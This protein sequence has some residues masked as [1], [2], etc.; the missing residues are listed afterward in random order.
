VHRKKLLPDFASK[1]FERWAEQQGKVPDNPEGYD[2]VLFQTCFVQNN[3][4]EL[5]RDTLA[6]LEKNGVKTACVSGLKCCGMPAWE[7]GDLD[8]MRSWAQTNLELLMPFVDAGAKVLAINPT[9]SM[10]LRREWPELLPREARDD[11]RRL[12]EATMDPG[13]YLWSIRKEPRFSR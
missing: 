3:A 8:R 7:H 4:P 1:T 5:G 11:A 6:V 12:A 10:M 9:C 13:E 2:A